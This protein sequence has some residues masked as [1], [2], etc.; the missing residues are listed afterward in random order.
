MRNSAK[1][2]L[3]SVAVLV[4]AA[5]LFS[6]SF[7][8]SINGTVTDSTGAVVPDSAI[9]LT[10]VAT[11]IQQAKKSD[12]AGNF[13]F[14]DLKPGTYM[15]MVS[16]VGFKEARSS[17]IILTANQTSR[18]DA[19]LE[20]G[21]P[22]Q[23]VEVRA[24]APTMNT[25]NAEVSGVLSNTELNILPVINRSTLYFIMTNSN[26]YAGNGSSH[27]LGGT[28]GTSTNFTIDG[29]SSNS[30]VFGNQVGP[31]TEESFDAV[32][33]LKT[34]VSNNSAEYPSVGTLMIA[35]RSG[36]NQ[37]HG[38]VFDIEKNN[39]LDARGFIPTERPRGPILHN[40]GA[41]LGGPV[42]IPHLYDGHNKTF[43]HF[44]YEGNYYPGE[45]SGTAEVPTAQMQQGDF[46]ELLD[47]GSICQASS[48]WCTAITDPATGQPF[49][50]NVIPP[51][52]IPQ[53]SKNVQQFGFVAPNALSHFVDGY[54]WVG[55]FPSSSHDNRYVV[56]VDHQA[57][58]KDSIAFRSSIRMIP[59]PKQY[60]D[61]T[62][63]FYNQS[64]STQNAFLGWTHSFRPNLLN[65]FRFG[66]S[67]D[68]SDLADAKTDG[69]ATTQALG[70]TGIDYSV[71]GGMSGFPIVNFETMTGWPDQEPTS[72]WRT[73]TEEFLDNLTLIKGKHSL[74]AG[75][76]I[77][78]SPQNID[79]YTSQGCCTDFGTVSFDGFASG[80]DYADFMLGIPHFA[81]LFT[82]AIP[83]A[84]QMNEWGMYVQDNYQASG[85]LTLNLGLR[86]DYFPSLTDK[87]D[88]NYNFDL[89]TGAVVL[90]S[91]RSQKYVSPL[92]AA[93]GVVSPIPFELP[94]AAGMP[95]RTLMNS[96]KH[97][98]G[99]RI[100]FAYRLF[101]NDRTVVRGG[102]GIYRNRLTYSRANDFSAGPF[103]SDP[104]YTNSIS[105]EGVPV[106]QFPDPFTGVGSIGTQSIA[107]VSTNLRTPMTQQWNLTVERQL[108]YSIVTSVTYR[109]LKTTQLPWGG[110]SN[111]PLPSSNPDG[112]SYFRY[113]NFYGVTQI[114]SGA[115]QNLHAMDLTVER[116]F[117]HG[118]TF[119][120]GWTWGHNLTDTASD[121][122]G[123]GSAVQ[124]FFD[125]KAEYGN[126]NFM[127]RHRWASYATYDLP[128][129]KGKA[130][131]PKVSNSLNQ[132]VGGWQMSAVTLLQT[133][134]F[135]T[136]TFDTF[137][138]S[139]TRTYGGRADCVTNPYPAQ[140][141]STHWFEK[142]AFAVPPDG[143]YGNC[144]NGVLVG[145]PLYNFDFGLFKNFSIKEKV[146][147]QLRMTSANVLNYVNLGNPKVDISR[148][149]FGKITTQAGSKKDTLG[150]GPRQILLGLR[151]EF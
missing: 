51:D 3:A 125:R 71:R 110:D 107:Y 15:V 121:T 91:E 142:S 79:E 54:D 74:K 112:E 11:G 45:Y 100:G 61:N 22:T 131:A 84:M 26:V 40:F 75:L 76:L 39:A 90:S 80:F 63:F 143:R 99:P 33:E 28:R 66:F 146:R 124:N 132:V 115:N 111:K 31:M 117:S 24:L 72:F 104:W 109:G 43:F 139:N 56:R 18:F 140:Q 46:S 147:V 21:S 98:I 89:N 144:G 88:L 49:S 32:G 103:S 35:T 85:R 83:S 105:D 20:V 17:D 116:R 92:Y 55:I 93:A 123:A 97:D 48:D 150:G 148:G 106:M 138:P 108:P 42:I 151:V 120:S 41:D 119:H 126:V 13:S 94:G 37:F 113:P 16:R 59:E 30:A 81:D 50:G 118:L 68:A 29:V 62:Q 6:Q 57:S 53:V 114:L 102:W 52:R 8:G 47:S 135:F 70:F 129:G 12:A 78:R 65:E 2:C 95:A 4:L 25:E 101:G 67:R 133:G 122:E 141:T 86:W 58:S 9:T 44:T 7:L 77:R 60:Y 69:V 149:T 1:L 134:Q 19:V 87:H 27:S 36:T 96:Q 73:Q 127:P 136:P 64:R 10:E 23:S 137:D 145:P 34:L 5:N 130:L 82:R 38:D 14:P 128:V